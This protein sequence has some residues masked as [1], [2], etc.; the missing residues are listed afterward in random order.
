[1]PLGPGS[2]LDAYEIVRP[3]GS[4][5]M[6]EVWLATE[7]RLGRK[8]A[9]KV[10]PADL[11]R[12]PSRV[13]RFEQ[14]ARAA[15]ALNHPNVCTIHALG[16]TSEGQHYIAMEYVEG[17]TLRH[18]FST[19]RLAIREAL[20]VAI[21][22]AA[23]LSAAHAAGIVHRDIKPENVMLRPDGFV[24]VLDF[25]LAKLA[26]APA[27][28]AG[29]D[30]T[31]MVLKTE[32]GVVVGTAAYMSPEQARGQEVD[33]RTDIW[34]LGVLL[35]EM[36]AGRSP[37]AGPTGT[38]VLAGILE[39]EPVP[40]GRFASKVPDELQR[41]VS[42]TLRKDREHRYQ[43]MKDLLLDLQAL[44]DALHSQAT[45]G[46]SITS[47]PQ[48]SAARALS[49]TRHWRWMLLLV[50]GVVAAAA[51][52]WS[53]I[54]RGRVSGLSAPLTAIPFTSFSGLE[55]APT[56]SP[57]GSQIA[58]A[59]SPEGHD[60][61]ADL[62]VKVM[63]SERAL[64]LTTTA[65]SIISPA[66]SPDGRQIAFARLAGANSGIFVIPALGGPER[67]LADAAFTYF[68]ETKLSWSH[69]GHSL[70]YY[71]S[72]A[73]D[74][75]PGITPSNMSAGRVV[76]LN[77]ETLDKRPLNHPSTD[78][79][80][81]WTPAF[82]PDGTA[83]A[84]ACGV[85]IGVNDLFVL[86]PA[87]GAGRRIARIEGE[88]GGL[89]WAADSSSIVFATE[90]DLWRVAISG[91]APEKLLAGL[92]AQNPTISRDGRRLAFE[93]GV[94]N[95]NVW[96]VRLANATR[97]DGLPRKVISSSRI[98]RNAAFSP[99]GRRVAF[100]SDRSGTSE[101]WI[102]DL[103]GSNA[104]ALTAFG[105]PLTSSPNWSPD[106]RSIAFDSRAGGRSSIYIVESNG[107]PP[108]RLE[109]GLADTA[110]PIWSPQGG[111]IY[112]GATVAGRPQIFKSAEHG[113]AATAIT[114]AGGDSLLVSRDGTRIY[115]IKDGATFWVPAA[116]GSETRLAGMPQLHPGFGKAR[117]L[118]A[119]GI[120]FINPTPP[121]GI[122]FFPFETQ[123]VVRVV[124]L[125]GPPAAWARLTL[126]P[127]ESR[128]LY[129]Q[130]D[131]V[132][133]DIMLVDNLR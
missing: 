83:L 17:D 51:A 123:R 90:G 61:Q 64:R 97:P 25:G 1:M 99:D 72:R 32:A 84:V 50:V 49:L 108:R 120:Y 86:P 101:I 121:A 19:T 103:D 81:S 27:E 67:K 13:Q 126:S 100:D 9:L 131:A 21:Q 76:L 80:W 38:D 107:G 33:A 34:S 93:D 129:A 85:T 119:S 65:A 102:S 35:Y 68:L 57:D 59:W 36:V 77:V 96:Q 130:L 53:Y 20:D 45:S 78:C 12:E 29:A 113:G 82:A 24:K 133:G 63:G 92:Y 127:D 94:T 91:G 115:Y 16:E 87:G 128:L 31:H 58:F 117:A 44:R 88:F 112:F 15:S 73:L 71:D 39:R 74:G 106:G 79:V 18:R 104:S 114:R 47:L 110:V 70:A 62:Y 4:G 69:D 22:V 37:F 118:G 28:I 116:G 2:R 52:W 23:A 48:G 14:E 66:W 125:P 11:T 95:I 40:L 26:P 105:G 109:T 89:T 75:H 7:V 6:G 54:S 111:W 56:F 122:D 98:Q 42:K 41:I 10:L 3:L 55:S 124:E 8:V 46:V 132:T 30:S 60:D 5:G 43:G